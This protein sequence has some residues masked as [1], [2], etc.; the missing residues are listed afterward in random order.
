MEQSKHS[1]YASDYIPFHLD[2]T[3]RR[4]EPPEWLLMNRF[5]PYRFV[6]P[7]PSLA[8]PATHS[9]FVSKEPADV[10]PFPKYL[11][12]TAFPVALDP[13]DVGLVVSLPPGS[14]LWLPYLLLCSTW[15][16]QVPCTA[17]W[18]LPLFNRHPVFILALFTILCKRL[19]HP[20]SFL[21]LPVVWRG[22]Q[23]LSEEGDPNKPPFDPKFSV[24]RHIQ[25]SR[26]QLE[27]MLKNT[28]LLESELLVLTSF[29]ER[30]CVFF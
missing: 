10:S 1:V 16:L 15:P 29:Y 17:S 19:P 30:L 6:A 14:V 13:T 2:K 5:I 18:S 3:C 26:R 27:Y 20:F 21:N 11:P 24:N 7:L 23:S 22:L 12:R 25:S 4:S 9:H 8:S 28:G